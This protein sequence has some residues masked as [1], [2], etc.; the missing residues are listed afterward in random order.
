[1]DVLEVRN[2]FLK[3]MQRLPNFD[4]P[5]PWYG[6]FF[7]CNHDPSNCQKRLAAIIFTD[8]RDIQTNM[9]NDLYVS[10]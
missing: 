5:R 1:M 8:R 3:W 7:R 9:M 10:T 6:R 4:F 2:C